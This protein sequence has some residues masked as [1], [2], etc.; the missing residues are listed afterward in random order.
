[1]RLGPVRLNDH[2]LR[3]GEHLLDSGYP[4]AG[5][6]HAAARQGTTMVTPALLDHSPQARASNC[7]YLW[8][9]R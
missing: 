8:I 6:I 3:P 1:M 2:G 4:S 7:Q 9:V 5:L